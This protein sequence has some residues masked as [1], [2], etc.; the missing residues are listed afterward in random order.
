MARWVDEVPNDGLIYYR[1]IFNADRILITSPKAIGEVLVQKSYDFV[2]PSFLRTS[3]SQILGVGILLAEGDEHKQQRKNLMPAF[4]F[5]HVQ[6]LYPEFWSRSRHLVKT[7]TTELERLSEAASGETKSDPVLDVANWTSRATLDIIGSAGMGHDFNSTENPDNELAAKYR[8]IFEPTGQ[9]RVMGLIGFFIPGWILRAL[10]VKRNDT[11]RQAASTIRRICR[12]IINETRTRMSSEKKR[13]TKDIVSVAIESG[14][15]TDDNLVNQM[16][17]FLAAGHETTATAMTWAIYE[18]CRRPELQVSLR[19]EVRANL[20]SSDDTEF[21]LSSTGLDKLPFLHAVCNEVLRT[22]P[23][24]ALTIREAAVNT[25]IL[26]QYVPAGTKV[27]LPPAAINVS[28]KLWGPDAKLFKPERWLSPGHAN[29]GGATNNYAYMTFLHGPRSCIGQQFAKAEFAALLAAMVGRFSFELEEPDKEIT[30]QAGI[31]ARPRDFPRRKEFVV[32]ETGQMGPPPAKR[33]RRLVVLSSEDEEEEQEEAVPRKRGEGRLNNTNGRDE[34]DLKKRALPTRL[35]S[36][37]ESSTRRTKAPPTKSSA[38]SP[39]KPPSKTRTVRKAPK[40]SYLDTYFSAADRAHGTQT[41]SS[42]TE[43]P[44]RIIEEEDFIEDDSFNEELRKLSDHRKT[45]KIPDGRHGAPPQSQTEKNDSKRLPGGSQVFRKLANG[46]VKADKNQKTP[47]PLS[48]DTRP[49]ADRYGPT[50]VEELA[51]HKRKVADVKEW[52]VGVLEGRLKQRMLLLKG[53]SGVGKTATVS[54]LAVALG[55][56]VLEWTNPTVS[57]FSSD[58]YLSTLSQFEDFL[59][60][61]GK[62]TSLLFKGSDNRGDFNTQPLSEH[63]RLDSK[64]KIILVEEFPNLFT[65]STTALQSFRNSILRHL[66]AVPA[67]SDSA[68]SQIPLI[69]IITESP[70]TTTTTSLTDTFTAHRLL[71]PSILAHPATSTIEFNPIA[72][73]FITK[74]LNLVIQKEARNSGRRRVPGPEVLRRLSEA[75]DVRSAIG[76][77]EFLCVKGQRGGDDNEWGGRVA[78]KGKKGSMT[79]SAMTAMEERSLELVSQR[80]ASL[81]L[82]HA[83]GKVVYNKREGEHQQSMK[84]GFT[85]QPPDHLAQHIRRRPPDVNPDDLLDETGTDTSTFIAALHENYVLS[86]S[87]DSFT[88]IVNACLDNLSDSDILLSSQHR[89]KYHGYALA[90]ETLRQEELA[91][92]VAVRGTLFSLP[93]PVHRGGGGNKVGAARGD[94]YQMFYPT[95]LRLGRQ[96]IEVDAAIDQFVLRRQGAGGDGGTV[97]GGGED[98]VL[99]WARRSVQPVGLGPGEDGGGGGWKGAGA[100][101]TESKAVMVM[102]ELPFM[103][104]IGRC[105]D[106]NPNPELER[107]TNV[108]GKAM[109][110]DSVVDDGIADTRPV[111][112]AKMTLLPAKKKTAPAIEEEVGKLY[113]SDD[114]IVD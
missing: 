98:D 84:E 73:T 103:A 61:S 100:C 69:L 4:A 12:E 7:M 42:Q 43:K 21:K 15:F 44:G 96:I 13:I 93:S 51:V 75:G 40:A 65:S 80:E 76:S 32:P 67:F 50:S 46:A 101:S 114:D 70:A 106:G 6:D 54:T 23:P 27:I 85:V 3:I 87:G 14:V 62:F 108:R 41:S 53:A 77:L 11:I 71:G 83:V 39:K 10:P 82:F 25:S 86:G 88:D 34:E 58:N 111:G 112:K 81:G 2:K 57:N 48:M 59:G 97:T 17:T 109:P 104:L 8:E 99:V 29:T 94:A 66:S 110:E 78:S 36:K 22:H 31:T 68:D 26:G 107:I 45:I 19:E 60:R 52:I 35:H 24:V 47:I 9:A 33:Q 79:A 5:R 28:T 63:A 72:P 18:L 89:G 1:F 113:L 30:L 37:H 64:K 105:R 49:W 16:M 74:A 91:F 95:S 56:G 102:E 90:T 20:P 38:P 92:A 55:F